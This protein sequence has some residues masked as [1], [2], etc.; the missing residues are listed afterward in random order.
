MFDEYHDTTGRFHDLYHG[1]DTPRDLAE[2]NIYNAG[3]R[4]RASREE[5]DPVE[6]TGGNL[7]G[8]RQAPPKEI[9]NDKK[10]FFW[11]DICYGKSTY[12]LDTN[13]LV[14]RLSTVK[15]KIILWSIFF[16]IVIFMLLFSTSDGFK[17]KINIEQASYVF[18]PLIPCSL[19]EI[20]LYFKEF[21]WIKSYLKTHQ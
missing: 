11:K 16:G 20:I 7:G 18:F 9:L 21:N 5:G 19:L 1:Y 3:K 17:T 4:A 15:K 12:K 8:P 2:E 14:E 10:T 6:I 13:F